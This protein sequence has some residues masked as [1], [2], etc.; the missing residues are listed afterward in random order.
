MPSRY[1]YNPER[2]VS[3][4]NTVAQLAV[5]VSESRPSPDAS[6]EQFHMETDSLVRQAEALESFFGGKR[7]LFLGDDDHMSVLL[8]AFLDISPVV[9][10]IDRRV[11]AS[12]RMWSERLHLRDYE[13]YEYDIRS[14]LPKP[15]LGLCDAF[16]INPPYSS[17]NGGYG[18][19]FWLTR[20]F[21][22]CEP[23]CDGVVVLPSDEHLPWVNENW[24]DIQSFISA[25]GCRIL[26]RG[27]DTQLYRSTN[28]LGLRSENLYL[29]RFDPSA[30]VKEMPRPGSAL[31]R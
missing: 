1:L 17:H 3:S 20:A 5:A 29:R 4:Y 16:Y 30:E 26:N 25:N 22:G 31:Y 24:R 12:L 2:E 11:V 7:L 19:R 28:D 21:E 15:A 9:F 23:F 14:P 10:E 8:A 18:I 27:K 6:L 13:V